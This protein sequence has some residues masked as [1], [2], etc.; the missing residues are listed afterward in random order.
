[1]I[2][3]S[4]EWN[5]MQAA[6]RVL[7]STAV[8]TYAVITPCSHSAALWYQYKEIKLTRF[9]VYSGS[10]LSFQRV[11]E[12][13]SSSF[14]F[15]LPSNRLAPGTAEKTVFMEKEDAFDPQMNRGWITRIKSFMEM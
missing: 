1:M 8:K 7:G 3:I 6:I 2:Y 13:N 15:R 5:D 4:V 9:V 10:V 11:I 14:S 12:H